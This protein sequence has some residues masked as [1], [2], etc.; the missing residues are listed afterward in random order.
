MDSLLNEMLKML[1][2]I[3]FSPMLFALCWST[4]LGIIVGALPGLTATMA[5]SLLIGLTYSLSTQNALVIIMGVYVGAIYGGSRAAILLN[6]PGTPS[7]AATAL[8]GYPLA[9][10]GRGGAALTIATIVSF[11]GTVL[12]VFILILTTPF[13]AKVALKFGAWEYFLLSVF[14]IMICGNLSAEEP[15]KGWIVGFLG[16]VISMIGIEE[17]F[18]YPRFTYGSIQLMGGISLIPAMIGMFG[19]PEVIS[20]LK[21]IS[22]TTTIQTIG[23]MMPEKG[24]FRKNWFT[25]LK[26]ALIGIFIGIVPGVGED[27]AAWVAYDA[28]KRTSKDRYL[29]G[30]GIEE[31]IIASE[32]AN[33]AAIGG[34]LV[35]M[36]ALS[37]PGSAVAAVILGALRLHGV[38]PGPLLFIESPEVLPQIVGMLLASSAAMLIFGVILTKLLVQILKVPQGILMPI[39]VAICVIGAFAV[40][41]RMFDVYL[42]FIFGILGYFMK[43]NGYPAA[44]MTLGIILGPMADANLRRAMMITK[45]SILPFFTRPISVLLIIGIIMMIVGQFRINLKNIT[46]MEEKN[47]SSKSN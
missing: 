46:I 37:V 47:D 32:T 23:S 6:I 3:F 15:I 22:E 40:N 5:V 21:K 2:E 31:G 24:W 25:A 10:K 33:N 18:A 8:D 4:I 39:V 1:K 26:S 29:F 42:L 28:A 41:M 45:G 9:K 17:I 34:A 14:G 19:I 7:A 16:L 43:E 12:G 30:T 11:L 20:S 36:L 38:R 27:V 35:P 44:P 13:L